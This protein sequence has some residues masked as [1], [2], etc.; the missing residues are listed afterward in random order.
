VESDQIVRQEPLE[1]QAVLRQQR[2]EIVRG[3]RRVEKEP[4]PSRE[5][6]AAQLQPQEHQV[7]VVDPDEIIG[8]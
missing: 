1:E 5:A 8:A 7:V 2:P 6:A 3:K 4:E